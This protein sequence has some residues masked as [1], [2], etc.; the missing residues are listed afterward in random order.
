MQKFFLDENSYGTDNLHPKLAQYQ[1]PALLAYNNAEFKKEHFQSLSQVGNSL[2][3]EDGS[4]TGKFGRGFNSVR[5]RSD[6]GFLSTNSNQV[7]NW[8]DSPS[9]VS[10][11]RVQI[12]DPHHSWSNG[13]NGY[14]FVEHSEDPGLKAH[15]SVYQALL[16]NAKQPFPGTI[17][18]L[19]LRTVEQA[20]ESGISDR[21]I[22]AH[23]MAH[24]LEKFT[25]D[26]GTEGLLFMKHVVKISVISKITGLIEIE[27]MNKKAVQL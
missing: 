11:H 14:N 26:F 10:G 9:I 15:M 1:G 21:N 20:K 6:L 2:K 18:R 4:T 12:L 17:I 3:M 16:E 19:P 8:T 7:Y 27:V 25:E 23:E 24:V 13:G 5:M 22:T